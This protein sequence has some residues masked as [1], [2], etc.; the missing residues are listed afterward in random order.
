MEYKTELYKPEVRIFQIRGF[1]DDETKK[2]GEFI[3]LRA[4]EGWEL[5]TYT[6]VNAEGGGM[7]GIVITFKR[8]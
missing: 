4:S 2:L 8:I 7:R 5:V 3:N 1:N 6:F